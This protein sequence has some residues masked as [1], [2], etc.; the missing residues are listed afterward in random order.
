MIYRR[1]EGVPCQVS[2]E[3]TELSQDRYGFEVSLA[4]MNGEKIVSHCHGHEI[5]DHKL[6][7]RALKEWHEYAIPL[8]V[9]PMSEDD[10]LAG[11]V[12]FSYALPE[13]PVF[14]MYRSYIYLLDP[15][16]NCNYSVFPL[17]AFT[18]KDETLG[19]F[20][21][22]MIRVFGENTRIIVPEL[23]R[24]LHDGRPD[25]VGRVALGDHG[26]QPLSLNERVI[27]ESIPLKTYMH[28]MTYDENVF[29]AWD[30]D[31]GIGRV[32]EY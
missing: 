24:S 11:S 25:E 26:L 10:A 21:D 27:P 14:G 16:E 32:K 8:I 7:L 20:F 30:F 18:Y 6:F 4:W 1:V 28:A 17:E 29:M 13:M 23:F 19:S 31:E 3:Q 2:F 22:R 5:T 9:P 12:S 15:N